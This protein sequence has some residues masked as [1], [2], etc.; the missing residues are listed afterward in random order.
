MTPLLSRKEEY[1]V[2]LWIYLFR[3]FS[4][5]KPNFQ[6]SPIFVRKEKD[7]ISDVIMENVH[8]D[9]KQNPEG[10]YQFILQYH[11]ILFT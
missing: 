7:T 2:I 5:T 11:S 4:K 10:I 6:D 1:E 9:T 8:S 3:I